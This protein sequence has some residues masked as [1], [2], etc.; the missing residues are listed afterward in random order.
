MKTFKLIS[1]KLLIFKEQTLIE[2]EIYFKDGLIINREDYDNSWLA[3]IYLSNDHFEYFEDLKKREKELMIQ[4]KI[5]KDTNEPATL[6]SK[7]IGINHFEDEMNVLFMGSMLTGRYID[8]QQTIED[9]I[10]SGLSGEVLL[11]RFK[12]M[13]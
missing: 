4:V 6:I 10:K 11:E 7:V 13:I 9:A 3:E 2:Q 8:I 12:S 1:L 5:T